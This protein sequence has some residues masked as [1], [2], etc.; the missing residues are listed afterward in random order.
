MDIEITYFI[1]HFSTVSKVLVSN[2]YL[3][4]S[5]NKTEVI[6]L[7]DS[8]V[9]CKDLDDFPLEIKF[10]VSANLASLPIICGGL[11]YNESSY[12]NTIYSSDKCF[13]YMDGGWQH[14]ATMLEKRMGA[15]GIIY[16]NAFHIFGGCDLDELDTNLRGCDPLDESTSLQSS[17]IVNVDGSSTKGPQL[18]RRFSSHAIATINSTVS[19]IT[20][21]FQDSDSMSDQTWYFNHET[22]EFQPGP[23][24]LEGR[25]NH[26]SGT[27]T[28]QETK[29][30]IVIVAGGMSELTELLLNGEWVAGKNPT[31]L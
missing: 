13:K 1:K 29:E 4:S 5:G 3:W 28:D 23:D 26:N 30:K 31:E 18:P 11:I 6:D 9:K 10:A 19:I 15:A 25:N 14:F 12:D 20:G 17:E 16:D 21:G 27:I 22:Q 24:L 8:N 7:V 2:G